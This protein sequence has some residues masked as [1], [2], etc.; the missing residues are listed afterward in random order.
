MKILLDTNVVLDVLLD[1]KPH[2][3]ESAEVFSLVEAGTVNGV[4][5]AT[6]LTTLDYLLCQSKPRAEAR[7]LIGLLLKLFDVAPV[8]RSVLEAA[9]QSRMTDFEDAVLDQSAVAACVDRIV[10]RNVKDFAL[11]KSRVCDPRQF[12]AM[13]R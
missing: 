9:L 5:C 11:A 4:L 3:I 1:R 8:S 2:S 10:T 13:L 7:T 6:T 12:L